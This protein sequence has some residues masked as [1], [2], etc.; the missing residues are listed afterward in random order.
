MSIIIGKIQEIMEDK[1]AEE[2]IEVVV[3]M[4]VGIGLEKGNFP[5]TMTAIELEVQ[6]IVGQGQ[7]LEQVQTGIE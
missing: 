4:K 5:E 1:A 3:M 2:I 6:A 7:D